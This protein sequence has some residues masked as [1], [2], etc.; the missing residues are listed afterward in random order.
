[1]R[2]FKIIDSFWIVNPPQKLYKNWW[3]LL[4]KVIFM[5]NI[6]FISNKI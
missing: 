1:M 6:Y 4:H 5:Q 3:N 2:I